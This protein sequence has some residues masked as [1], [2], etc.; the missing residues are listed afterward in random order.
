MSVDAEV[1]ARVDLDE[2]AATVTRRR[3]IGELFDDNGELRLWAD[4]DGW[5][6]YRGEERCDGVVYYLSTPPGRQRTG[7]ARFWSG[8]EPFGA[9]W[10]LLTPTGMLGG[11]GRFERGSRP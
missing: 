3:E 8:R 7:L 2:N 1:E 5:Q 4:D 10:S 6:G 9:P 11:L